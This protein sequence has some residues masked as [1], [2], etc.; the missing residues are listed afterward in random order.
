[1]RETKSGAAAHALQKRKGEVKLELRLRFGLRRLD[2]AFKAE[3][4]QRKIL[5]TQNADR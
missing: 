3:P 1:L 4:F 5:D 2:A